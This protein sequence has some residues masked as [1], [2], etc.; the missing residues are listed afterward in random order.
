MHTYGFSILALRLVY[1]YLKNRKQ[2]TKI[3]SSYS[4][5]EE[6]LFGIPQRSIL[7]P[8]LFNIS[9]CD[10]FYMMNDSDFAS[11]ADDNTP[12]FS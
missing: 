12:Y 4:S 7:E 10:L 5:W 6:I 2:K 3:N 1:S 9:L 8:L 11:N